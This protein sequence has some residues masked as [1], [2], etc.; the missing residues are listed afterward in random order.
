MATVILPPVPSVAR[1]A[2]SGTNQGQK[3]VNIFHSRY[4]NVP[5]D[6]PTMNAI[7]QAVHTAYLN[8]FTTLWSPNCVL[9]TVDGQDLS[10][11]QGA[12]GTFSLTHP[13]T[14]AAVQEMAVQV[15]LCLSW[16]I[17]DRYRGGHPRTYLPGINGADVTGGRLLTTAGHTAYLNAAAAFLTNMNAIAAGASSWQMCCVRYFSQHMLLANPLVRVIGGQSVHGRIDTQRRRLGKEVP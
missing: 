11:R 6:T 5:A 8:A 12:V 7:C 17:T 1:F 3:W 15:A 9:I 13:G 2:V 16:S 10:S 4:T 14:G